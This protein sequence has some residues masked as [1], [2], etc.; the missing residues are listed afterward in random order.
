MERGQVITAY[1]ITC[2]SGDHPVNR[3]AMHNGRPELK[4]KNMMK[5]H[6]RDDGCKD[7]ELYVVTTTN[8]SALRAGLNMMLEA[9]S[10][11]VRT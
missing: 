6:A 10:A 3:Y 4:Q 8:D 5:L 1:R 2:L 11:K 9:E 7:H